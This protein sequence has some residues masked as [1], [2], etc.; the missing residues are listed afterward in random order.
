MA[1]SDNT[2][3]TVHSI[4]D[5]RYHI[6]KSW[7]YACDAKRTSGLVTLGDSIEEGNVLVGRAID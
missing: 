5:R 6:K 3:D 2:Y 4:L 1:K 7:A